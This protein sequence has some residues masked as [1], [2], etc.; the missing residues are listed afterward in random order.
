MRTRYFH[1]G[2]RK[3]HVGD[4]IL[5]PATTKVEVMGG[6]RNPNYRNDRVYLAINREVAHEYASASP[7]PVV[8]EAIP[9]E[10][11]ADPDFQIQIRSPARRRA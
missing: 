1:G 3:L 4:Y 2:N 9:E 8:Y 5:P 6:W 11:E 7:K 10:I